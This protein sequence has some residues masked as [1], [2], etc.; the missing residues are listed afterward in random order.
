MSRRNDFIVLGIILLI[1]AGGLFYYTANPVERTYTT[2][3][4]VT[5]ERVVTKERIVPHE[6]LVK[7]TRDVIVYTDSIIKDS[8]KDLQPG[9]FS[10]IAE[11]IL[12]SSDRIKYTIT[13]DS[14]TSAIERWFQFVI[15]DS[16]NYDLWVTDQTYDAYYESPIGE[17]QLNG[18]W[19]VPVTTETK[20]YKLVISNKSF[21]Y[22][23]RV[24]YTI[25]KQEASVTTQ[26]YSQK[27]TENVTETYEVKEPYQELETVTKK[28]VVS[29]DAYKPIS[30]IIGAFGILAILIGFMTAQREKIKRIEDFRQAIR[31]KYRPQDIPRCPNCGSKVIDT[32]IREDGVEL[33]KCTFCNHLFDMK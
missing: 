27:V 13:T 31:A 2:Q 15:L 21:A 11:P 3:E 25:I 29:L 6:T 24:K 23:K 30:Y 5:K 7:K 19:K 9:D 17:V 8:Y 20:Q 12:K 14:S 22:P 16:K 1:V 18:I 10:I 32:H 33:Y 28:E 26:E 4:Y